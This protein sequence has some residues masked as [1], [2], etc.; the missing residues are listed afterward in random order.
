MTQIPSTPPPA[1]NQRQSDDLKKA[2]QA[3]EALMLRQLLQ[4]V[5]PQTEGAAPLALDALANQLATQSP[6]GFARLMGDQ[7]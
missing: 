6:F 1:A 3:F 7:K 2:G 5:L 4:P